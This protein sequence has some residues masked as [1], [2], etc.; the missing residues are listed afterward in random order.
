MLCCELLAKM[1]IVEYTHYTCE[2]EVVSIIWTWWHLRN[3]WHVA[4]LKLS[5]E[6]EYGGTYLRNDVWY[7][8][9]YIDRSRGTPFDKCGARSGLPQLW[10]HACRPLEDV[11]ARLHTNHCSIHL[12][13]SRDLWL[14]IC[15]CHVRITFI[16]NYASRLICR[17]DP[18]IKWPPQ[19]MYYM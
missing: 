4:K 1:C 5:N 11:T 19:S 15:F 2:I 8:D 12:K 16:T 6:L 14:P 9:I 17:D 13:W 3:W 10:I 18:E 7:I